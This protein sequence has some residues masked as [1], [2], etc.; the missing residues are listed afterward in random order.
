VTAAVAI[1]VRLF[2]DVIIHIVHYSNF[3]GNGNSTDRDREVR[4]FEIKLTVDPVSQIA[5]TVPPLVRLM[6]LPLEV[7]GWTIWTGV[8]FGP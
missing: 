1:S 8:P 4:S 7:D 5:V 2:Q 3:D 6:V